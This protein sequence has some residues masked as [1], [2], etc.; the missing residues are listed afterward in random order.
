MKLL[1]TNAGRR[2]YLVRYALD[3][4]ERGY[5][6]EVCVS[7]ATEQTAAMHVA[8]QVRTFLTPMVSSGKEAYATFLLDLCRREQIGV[9]IPLMDYEIPVLSRWRDR[10]A[11]AGTQVW[12]SSSKVTETC[13][14]KRECYFFCR[15]HDLPVPRSWFGGLDEKVTFPLIRKR[16]L[17]SGSVGQSILQD[18]AEIPQADKSFFYQEFIEGTEYGIDI[19]NDYG[20]NYVHSYYREKL[21]MR[22]G[23]TDKARSLASPRLERFA[24]KLSETFQ[25]VGNMDTDIIVDHKGKIYLIDLNPRFG[26]GYPFTHHSGFDYLKGILEMAQGRMPCF[27]DIGHSITGMKGLTLH[28]YLNELYD[29]G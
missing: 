23:E 2:T 18:K 16:V 5:P 4:Q 29:N 25:H 6:L 9:V 28:Y 17:G 15:E 27:P 26:G 8:P 13:L 19:L 3:L 14:D 11:A 12:V 20:G 21:L 1:F 24:R 7:D 22:A 10:F